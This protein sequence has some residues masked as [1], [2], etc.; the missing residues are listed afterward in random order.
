MNKASIEDRLTVAND[1][2][3]AAGQMVHKARWNG[4]SAL[5]H[6]EQKSPQDFVTN[7]DRESERLIRDGLAQK[8][9]ADG[10]LGEES[11]GTIRSHATW[12]VDPIDGT[13]NFIR[14]F[15]HW[16]VS[17]ALVSENEVV[18]G[19]VYNAPTDTTYWAI[20][21]QGAYAGSN[22]LERPK[23][24][25][26]SRSLASVGFNHQ[27]DI[28]EHKL[29]LGTLVGLGCDLRNNGSA[30]MDIVNVAQ[31]KTDLS[32]VH[33][34]RPW[35]VLAGLLIAKEAG[36]AAYCPPLPGFMRGAGPVLSGDKDLARD[37]IDTLTNQTPSL[38]AMSRL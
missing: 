7:M 20:A 22:R 15:D 38:G 27:M 6:V 13:T 37:L 21:G 5:L 14:G 19:V 32:F 17:I 31:G 34:L 28:E 33:I 25:V 8:F 29:L 11:D 10:F 36:A 9:P 1:L 16:S 12:V 18:A 26:R 3:R 2:A 35:D 30:A 23:D 4:N 24:F